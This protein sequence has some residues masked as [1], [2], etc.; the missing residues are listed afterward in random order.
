MLTTRNFLILFLFILLFTG[1]GTPAIHQAIA[2]KNNQQLE[3]LVK[4]G[5]D[6]EEHYSDYL[7]WTPLIHAIQT[8]NIDAVRL[9]VNRGADIRKEYAGS[10]SLFLAANQGNEEM[11][12]L[13]LSKGLDINSKNNLGETILFPITRTGK[14]PLVKYL[15]DN[16]ANINAVNNE[17]A[18]IM[19]TSAT[20][21]NVELLDFLIKKGL[22]ANETIPTGITPIFN[23]VASGQQDALKFLIKNGANVHQQIYD[24]RTALFNV[25]IM[26]K[27]KADTIKS[28]LAYPSLAELSEKERKNIE[29]LIGCWK[30]L[31]DAKV[32]PEILDNT[33]KKALDYITDYPNYY[34][35]LSEYSRNKTKVIVE[36]KTNDEIQTKINALMTKQDFEGLK[37]LTEKNPNYVNYISNDELRIMLTGPKGMKVGDIKKLLKNGK[38]DTIVVSLIKRV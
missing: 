10:N 20:S 12:K 14:L 31:I 38:S 5:D 4:N 23:A 26:I 25:P 34:N 36:E 9:L 32:D 3:A 11:I 37:L 19:F 33:N 21:G 29:N 22:S 24:K 18:N 17:K 27:I 8:G 28:W 7:A 6:I 13:I 15:L 35:I 16:G 1:C 2:T 30:V